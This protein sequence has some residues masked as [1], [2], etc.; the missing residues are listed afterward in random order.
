M[1]ARV[2][3]LFVAL[4]LLY[5]APGMLP[6]RRLVP[7]DIPND[8]LAWKHDPAVRVRVSN[9]LLS[10]VPLQLVPWDTEARRLLARGE[11]PWRNPYAG[12]SE[13]LFANPLAAQLSPFTWP[14]FLLGLQGWPWTVFLKLLVAMLSMYWFATTLGASEFAASISAIVFGLSGYSI[15]WALY[16]HTNVLVVL[17]ALAASAME[18]RIFTTAIIAAIATAGG[19]PET[20]CIGVIAIFAFILSARFLLSS[21]AGFLL[22]G[23]QLVPFAILMARSHIRFARLEQLAP[24]FRKFSLLALILPGYLGS[25]LR[26]ELDLTGA[27]HSVENFNQRAGAYVGALVL[28]SIALSFRRLETRYKRAVVIAVVA[29]VLSL[30]FGHMLRV[31]PIVKWLALEYYGA[32]F[33][34]FASLAAGP[35]IEQLSQSRRFTVAA[36]G[37]VLLVAGILPAAAPQTLDRAARRGVARLR[38]SGFLQ[39]SAEVYEQ[40]LSGYLASAKWTAVRRVAL[41]GLCWMIFG[42]ARRRALLAGAIVAEL[43]ALGLGY[44]PS[45][46]VSEV[47]RE[48]DVVRHIHGPWLIASSNAVFPPNMATL[49]AI[50]DVRAYDILTSE[51]YTRSLLP[52]GYDALHWDLPLVPSPEQMRVLGRLGV[53]YYIVPD[54]VIEIP[55]PSGRGPLANTPPDG[56]VIGCVVSLLGAAL[57]VT[58]QINAARALRESKARIQNA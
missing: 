50:R 22:L 51:E 44:N 38:A 46:A 24:A 49:S 29:L 17:P 3:I 32:A 4:S 20:L 23:V 19:H 16:P 25:P 47:A 43:L 45:I 53:R 31:I 10:D 37:V 30:G 58:L 35:A 33:V 56:I 13:H 42:L 26:G 6:G 39:Q 34:L 11:I 8:Y 21:L 5:T 14:R 40:R 18:R 9:S 2:V 27:V 12:D 48:P 54:G 57:L 28:L 15:V 7:L 1:R 55:A 36:L 41:P 52:A